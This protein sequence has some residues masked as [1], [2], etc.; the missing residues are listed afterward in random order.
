MRETTQGLVKSEGAA[1]LSGCCDELQSAA[2]RKKQLDNQ[3]L[4]LMRLREARAGF[5]TKQPS[6]PSLVRAE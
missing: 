1:G 4:T 5:L 3:H 6:F 2:A